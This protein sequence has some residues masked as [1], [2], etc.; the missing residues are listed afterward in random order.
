MTNRKRGPVLSD[1]HTRG[2]E[3]WLWEDELDTY[4]Q[5]W[6][7]QPHEVQVRMLDWHL[8]QYFMNMQQASL[9]RF[10]AAVR[11]KTSISKS[12][13]KRYITD[14]EKDYSKSHGYPYLGILTP[15]RNRNF[16]RNIID[17]WLK[18]STNIRV[19]DD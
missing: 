4:I 10:R 3:F 9:E 6:N 11:T 8:T 15:E 13:I 16:V 5:K 17:N 19:L 12:D 18:K 2:F 1:G 7:S 14:F